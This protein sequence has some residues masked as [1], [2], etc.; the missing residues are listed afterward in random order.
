MTD[1]LTHPIA[2]SLAEWDIPHVELA[3]FGTAEPAHIAR[4]IETTCLAALHSPPVEVLFYQSS[5]G[6]V[7]GVKL[8]SGREVVVKGHQPSTTREHLAEIVRLQS[9][10]ASKLRLAPQVLAGPMPFGFGA[11]IIEEFVDRGSIRNG[12]EAAIR[13][14]LARSLH[15]VVVCL[16]SDY[17]ASAL[18]PGLMFDRSR[19][20]LW[21]RPHSKLFDFDATTQGAAYIDELAAKASARMVPAGRGVIGHADWRAE[22]VRFEGNLASVAFDWDSLCK[23]PEPALVG[24]AAHMF[25]SE[26]EPGRPRAGTHTG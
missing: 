10:I 2:A 4:Q 6:T 22:H 26:L 16:S 21:P 8:A 17:P 12:H 19:D 23:T 13:A 7:A 3:I 18:Q 14:G 24:S 9:T 5:V 1:P 11:A 20:G 15:A 25:C